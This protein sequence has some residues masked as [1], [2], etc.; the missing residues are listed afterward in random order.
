MGAAR[1]VTPESNRV[2]TENLGG[3]SGVYR[4]HTEPASETF[5]GQKTVMSHGTIGSA[6]MGRIA[7]NQHGLR[8]GVIKETAR[9][10]SVR[11]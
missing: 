5:R 11:A 4:T 9:A 10:V 7:M 1:S 2:V 8:S 6:F 3:N